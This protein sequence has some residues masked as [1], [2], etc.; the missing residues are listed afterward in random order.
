MHLPE[1]LSQYEDEDTTNWICSSPL[2]PITILLLYR[3]FHFIYKPNFEAPLGYRKQ[4]TLI[5][6]IAISCANIWLMVEVINNKSFH[7]NYNS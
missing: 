6:N 5:K 4:W 3:G 2:F 7:Y 1:I